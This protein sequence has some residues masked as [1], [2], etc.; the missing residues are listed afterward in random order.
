MLPH[1]GEPYASFQTKGQ[2]SIILRMQDHQMV[3]KVHLQWRLVCRSPTSECA[4]LEGTVT[5]WFRVS[6]FTGLLLRNL[7]HVSILGIYTY[8]KYQGFPNIVT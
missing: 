3:T 5:R 8:S 1:A 4:A 7:E 6:D 2:H